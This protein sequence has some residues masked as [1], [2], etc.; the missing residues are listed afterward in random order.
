MLLSG[1]LVGSEVTRGESTLGSRGAQKVGC[2][3]RRKS[4]VVLPPTSIL[5]GGG[6]LSSMDEEY[7]AGPHVTGE[8][9]GTVRWWRC[10]RE[11]LWC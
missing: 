7:V 6:M 1:L 5:V 3:E 4:W 2:V 9:T 10:K 8:R 11:G